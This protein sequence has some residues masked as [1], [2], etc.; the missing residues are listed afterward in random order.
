MTKIYLKLKSKV[1]NKVNIEQE[2]CIAKAMQLNCSRVNL[3]TSPE[4]VV[5]PLF[6][7]C[8]IINKRMSI[9][10]NLKKN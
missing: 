10:L 5:Y 3:T 2:F 1:Q 7:E 4:N 9:S 6:F 8:H